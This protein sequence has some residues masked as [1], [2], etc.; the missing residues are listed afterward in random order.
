MN[1]GNALV[2]GLGRMMPAAF[3]DR[4]CLSMHRLRRD[5]QQYATGQ[6]TSVVCVAASR[7]GCFFS[8]FHLET[9]H[10]QYDA[11]KTV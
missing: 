7:R 9:Y 2:D 6:V 11:I 1:S 10:E 4:W 3:P 5:R 8:P